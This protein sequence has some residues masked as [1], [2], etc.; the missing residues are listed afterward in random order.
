MP[1][2]VITGI[3]LLKRESLGYLLSSS[4]LI[5][6]LI[7]GLSVIAGETMLGLS[8][9]RMNFAGVAVFSIFVGVALVLLIAVLAGIK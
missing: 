5:L 6:F 9:G 7:V 3:L 1:F 4:S 8:T 2:C